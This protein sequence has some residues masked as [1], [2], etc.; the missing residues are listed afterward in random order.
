MPNESDWSTRWYPETSLNKPP[1]EMAQKILKNVPESIRA[2]K[3]LINLSMKTDLENGLDIETERH[4]Q[5]LTS[6][7]EERQK[8][9]SSFLKK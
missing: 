8:R 4:N 6:N 7:P 9:I 1:E 3:S 5:G 2:V